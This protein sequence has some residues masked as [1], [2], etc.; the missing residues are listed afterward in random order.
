M[1]QGFVQIAIFCG[2]L[3]AV[4]PLLGTYM[5]RVYQNERVFL[6]P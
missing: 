1:T 2:A 5:A 4:M 3:V 6:T